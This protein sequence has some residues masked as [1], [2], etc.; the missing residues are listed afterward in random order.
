MPSYVNPN[1]WVACNQD[2]T[3][4]RPNTTPAQALRLQSR[5]HASL[6]AG[7]KPRTLPRKSSRPET[8]TPM[9]MGPNHSRVRPQSG[10]VRT[11]TPLRFAG[12]RPRTISRNADP[13]IAPP[14]PLQASTPT[15]SGRKGSE[16]KARTRNTLR[17]PI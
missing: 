14:V 6:A 7:A 11:Q 8:H 3:R 9:R 1:P 10:L 16:S 17:R 15:R 13:K 2:E 12:I 5:T 4:R